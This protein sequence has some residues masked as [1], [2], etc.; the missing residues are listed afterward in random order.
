LNLANIRDQSIDISD[1]KKLRKDIMA[2]FF[3]VLMTALIN[4]LKFWTCMIIS[5][6]I[7]LETRIWKITM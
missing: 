2:A 1:P 5:H 3:V 6:H 4:E 7:N